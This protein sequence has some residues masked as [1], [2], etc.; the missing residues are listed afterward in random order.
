MEQLSIFDVFDVIPDVKAE[1][2]TEE[3][4]VKYMQEATGLTF[5][6]K[7]WSCCEYYGWICK[8][9]KYKFEFGFGRYNFDEHEKYIYVDVST[10]M[11]GSSR[12][13]PELRKAIKC[14]KRFVDEALGEN[15]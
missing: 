2:L 10:S 8:R 9:K 6:K 14:M 12:T 13:Y 7:E 15:K 1:D 4:L 3:E 11:W 5:V